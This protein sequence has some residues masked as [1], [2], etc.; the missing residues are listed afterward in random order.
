MAHHVHVTKKLVFDIKFFYLTPVEAEKHRPLFSAMRFYFLFIDVVGVP[1]FF[2]I[3]V[4]FS[5]F[6]RWKIALSLPRA[7]H[8]LQVTL[9]FYSVF[10]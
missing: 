9:L 6:G 7:E 10:I 8:M 5:F 1:L 3:S 2:C 4:T